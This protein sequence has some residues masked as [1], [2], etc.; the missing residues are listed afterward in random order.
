MPLN[1]MC[2]SRCDR[3]CSSSRSERDPAPT[4]TPR[5]ALSRWSMAW[6]TTV[7]PEGSGRNATVIG[8]K[9]PSSTARARQQERLDRRL[10]VGD[11]CEVSS[12]PRQVAR[13]RPAARGC[14]AGGRLDRGR[15]LRRVGGRKGD[16]R[17]AAARR[18]AAPRRARRRCA[19]RRRKP[20]RR[21]RTGGWWRR[22]RPRRPGRRRNR[23]GSRSSGA[24]DDGEGAGLA[25]S[26]ISRRPLRRRGHRP[27]TGAARSSTRPGYP[28][29]ARWWRGP[30]RIS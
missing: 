13:S 11:D 28:S 27:R 14:T 7:R 25:R 22:S 24:C 21:R 26:S 20:G 18:S 29:T 17:H 16:H 6:V 2:S 15:E 3:P 12:R 5:A 8:L 9:P 19:D 23:P 30:P 10:I 4:Q 1:A